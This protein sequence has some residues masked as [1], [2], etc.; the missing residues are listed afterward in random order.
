[1]NDLEKL[2]RI[3]ERRLIADWLKTQHPNLWTMPHTSSGANMRDSL[4]ELIRSGYY[5]K[6]KEKK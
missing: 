1:M 4:S 3:N 2:I 5:A 6:E